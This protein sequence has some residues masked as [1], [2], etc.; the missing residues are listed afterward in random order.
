MTDTGAANAVTSFMAESCSLPFCKGCGHGHVLRK[1]NDAMV[2]LRLDPQEGALR[3]L[4]EPGVARQDQRSR[5]NPEEL[6]NPHAG[7]VGPDARGR[8]PLLASY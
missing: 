8:R 7:L 2:Q 1:L 5:E 6:S 3:R 4:R